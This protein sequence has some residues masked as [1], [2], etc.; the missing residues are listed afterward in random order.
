MTYTKDVKIEN[1][2]KI[3]END[4]DHEHTMLQGVTR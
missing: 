2:K 3:K 4:Q 1:R